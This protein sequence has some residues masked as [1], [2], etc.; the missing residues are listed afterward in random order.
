MKAMFLAK[1]KTS[2][3]VLLAFGVL[4]VGAGFFGY[5]MLPG[6]E[7]KGP[8]DGKS[9]TL[10]QDVEPLKEDKPKGDIDRLR[11]ENE[12]LRRELH[13]L[14]EKVTSLERK[15]TPKEEETQPVTFQGKPIDYWLQ[16]FKDRDP[17]YRKKAINA[18]T[19]IGTEDK[20][21][22]PVLIKALKDRYISNEAA[23][24]LGNI[25]KDAVPALLPLLKGRDTEL[26]KWAAVALSDIGP[27]AKETIP[28]LIECLED[29]DQSLRGWAAAALGRMAPES[30]AAIPALIKLLDKDDLGFTRGRG[31]S[32]TIEALSRFREQAVPA[33]SEALKD[34]SE[35]IRAGAAGCL[36]IIGKPAKGAIPALI[37]A[38]GDK[39]QLVRENAGFGLIAIEDDAVPA[40]VK[41]LQ[42][43]RDP[44]IRA[45]VAM[46]LGQMASPHM[47]LISQMDRMGSGRNSPHMHCSDSKNGSARSAES[48][49]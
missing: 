15:L 40:L 26:R 46:V 22:L 17:E 10:S 13:T 28:A 38:L 5:E 42:E 3:A 25:G 34:P 7:A 29:Q 37:L 8:A 48:D 30:K 43:E 39:H 36:A 47:G 4:G 6:V 45:A 23:H 12:D 20:R 44:A 21:V 1:L 32:T 49:G 33:L 31:G 24:A 16:M 14:R 35:K 2:A 41:A 9:L 11:R 18:L 19:A 27:E